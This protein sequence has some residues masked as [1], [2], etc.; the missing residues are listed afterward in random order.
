MSTH[1]CITDTLSGPTVHRELTGARHICSCSLRGPSLESWEQVHEGKGPGATQVT[2]PVWSGQVLFCPMTPFRVSGSFLFIALH[3]LGLT[4]LCKAEIRS[5]SGHHR[6]S[7]P[8]PKEGK[9]KKRKHATLI[10]TSITAV[11]LLLIIGHSG[12][13][14]VSYVLDG[15]VPDENSIIVK[16]GERRFNWTVL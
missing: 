8:A 11:A 10:Y 15:P 1:C 3:P 13:W 9:K 2:L 14:K 5:P 4:T 7:G 16:D 6:F 12:G